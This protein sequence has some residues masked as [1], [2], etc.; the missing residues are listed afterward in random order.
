MGNTVA[1]R[2]QSAH[3]AEGVELDYA[4]QGE[5]GDATRATNAI[6]RGRGRDRPRGGWKGNNHITKLPS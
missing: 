2:G 5:F 4:S 6:L 3:N 1:K